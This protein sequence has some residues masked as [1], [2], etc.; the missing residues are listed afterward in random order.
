[1]SATN[2]T[3]N[4]NLPIF[5]GSDKPAWLVDFNGAMN[6]IDAQMKA[7]ADAIAGKSPILTF[8][9][10]TEI[11]FTV[12]S[13]VITANLASGVSDKVGRALVTPI[14]A[15]AAE[16]IVAINTSG[17][18]DV[19]EI[20]S[21]LFNDSG[22]LKAVDL[23]LTDTGTG[24]FT[25]PSN[26]NLNS[27]NL[28]YALNTDKSI[29]KIYGNFT[30]GGTGTGLL[31]FDTGIVVATPDAEYTISTTGIVVSGSVTGVGNI[32]FVVHTNGH[33]YITVYKPTSSSVFVLAFPCLYFFK[34]F[35]DTE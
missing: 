19:I 9:D 16:Q 4:Y 35:G 20:G 8:N 34:D 28:N 5:I 30:L 21:G 33:V 17:T 27:G 1:M 12:A 26:I 11:D 14:A 32:S 22:T 2:T 7:N 23:N 18:Q 13:N 10:T 25:L 3:T 29:G 15:P 6:A 31:N 24:S